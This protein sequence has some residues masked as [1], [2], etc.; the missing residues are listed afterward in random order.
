VVGRRR[1]P[2]NPSGI[3]F[4]SPGLAA[5]LVRGAGVVPDDLVFDLGAGLGELTAPLAATGARVVAVER[6]P[7]YARSLA[8]RFA[9]AGN[10]TIVEGDLLRVPLPR[11]DFRV[12]ANIPFATTTTA[13]LRRLL[14]RSSRLVRADLVVQYD[15]ARRLA[16]PPR[17]ARGRWWAARYDLRLVR[18][19]PARCFQPVPAV[20]AAL[21]V[22]ER[23]PLSPAAE[24]LLADLLRASAAEP[25]LSVRAL[26]RGRL[27]GGAGP[28]LAAGV[29]P[30][31]PAG[32]VPPAVWR[33]VA[34]RAVDARVVR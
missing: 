24:R 13:L 29:A 20:D 11:R 12:V 21:L 34:A 19:I 27:P 4:L 31:Q 1:S 3:H 23:C 25:A 2:A 28:L 16:G 8:R 9:A 17:D 22:V 5:E 6:H 32:S 30:G 10:V 14:D 7:G 18:R 15:A 26:V 33:A